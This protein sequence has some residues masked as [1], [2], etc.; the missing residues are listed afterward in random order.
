M[1]FPLF[2][3]AFP[4]NGWILFMLLISLA[5]PATFGYFVS[6]GDVFRE[7]LFAAG[8]AAAN[9]LPMDLVLSFLPSLF[10]LFTNITFVYI[11]QL[12]PHDTAHKG[13]GQA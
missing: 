8:L 6:T 13:N 4:T 10:F 2:P 12:P 11:R 7:F 9:G 3:Q 5:A 1:L